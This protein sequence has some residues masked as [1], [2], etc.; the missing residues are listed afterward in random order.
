MAIIKEYD[1]KKFTDLLK[2]YAFTYSDIYD[3]K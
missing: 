3:K 1:E 2:K